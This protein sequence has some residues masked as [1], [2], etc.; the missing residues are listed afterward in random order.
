VLHDL[1]VLTA[2]LVV[3]FF[4]IIIIFIIYVPNAR[5]FLTAR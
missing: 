4:I 2:F 1:P 3:F 5:V